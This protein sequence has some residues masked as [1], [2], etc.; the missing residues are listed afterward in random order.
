MTRPKFSFGYDRY[1]NVVTSVELERMM[2]PLGPTGGKLVRPSDGKEAKNVAFTQCAGSRDKNHL[3]HCSRICCMASLKQS[4]Y[5]REQFGDDGK[6]LF[7]TS[8]FAP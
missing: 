1:E 3:A 6:R 2:D 8:T 5:L 7:I 4:T